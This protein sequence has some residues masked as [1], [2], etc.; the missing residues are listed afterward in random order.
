MKGFRVNQ[1][2]QQASEEL[3]SIFVQHPVPWGT[4]IHPNGLVQVYDARMV[5]IPILTMTEVLE[6]LTGRIA[7]QKEAKAATC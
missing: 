5:E 6:T 7:A 4:V 1:Q 3:N 2:E